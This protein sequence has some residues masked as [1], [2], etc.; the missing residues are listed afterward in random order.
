MQREKKSRLW[1]ETR[2]NTV[3]VLHNQHKITL[4][5][6]ESRLKEKVDITQQKKDQ[7]EKVLQCILQSKPQEVTEE[8]V[9]TEETLDANAEVKECI[10][11]HITYISWAST[12]EVFGTTTDASSTEEDA[13]QGTTLETTSADP[14]TILDTITASP[15]TSLTPPKPPSSLHLQKKTVRPV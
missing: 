2:N 5:I 15:D 8:E 1:R 13:E 9:N 14:D 11:E 6:L 10:T 12:T 3:R 7:L 4:T